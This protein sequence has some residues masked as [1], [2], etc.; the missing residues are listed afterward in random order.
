M[1]KRFLIFIMIML[2]I[3]SLSARENDTDSMIASSDS[4]DV[5]LE[6]DELISRNLFVEFYGSPETPEPSME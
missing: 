2:T 3:N 4:I 6:K 5:R 1:I